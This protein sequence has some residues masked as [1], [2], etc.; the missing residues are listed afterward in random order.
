MF[1]SSACM[2]GTLLGVC[3][4][5]DHLKCLIFFCASISEEVNKI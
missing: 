2:S 3:A 4:L 5:S 1:I